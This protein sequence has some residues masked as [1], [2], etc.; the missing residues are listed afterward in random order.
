MKDEGGV[1]DDDQDTLPQAEYEAQGSSHVYC[2]PG[3]YAE[4]PFHGK[5]DWI[6]MLEAR[7]DDTYLRIRHLSEC[8]LDLGTGRRAHL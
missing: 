8:A 5:P 6:P 2:S 1:V 4:P 3:T 7:D